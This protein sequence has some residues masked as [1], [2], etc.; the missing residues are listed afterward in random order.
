MVDLPAALIDAVRDQQ[1]VLFFGAGANFGATHPDGEKIPVGDGLR[2]LICDKYFGGSMKSKSLMSVSAFAANEVGL[3][4]FQKYIRDLLE[5]FGPA[6]Y[7]ELLPTFRW[8]AIATTNYDLIVERAYANAASPLQQLIQ[9]FKDNDGFGMRMH[10]ASYPLGYYKLH[11]CIDHYTDDSIPLIL[12]NEQ[13][14]SYAENRK[15]FYNRLRDLGYEFPFIFAGYSITDS[16]I[17]QVLF[18]LT[19]A[20]VKR[21]M[22]YSISPDFEDAEIRY[23]A[24]HRVQCIKMTLEGFLRELDRQIPATARALPAALGGGTLSIRSHY[25]VANATES[26]S[27]VA[28]LATDATHVHSAMPAQQQSP[29]EFYRGADEGWGAIQQNLDAKRTFADSV[30]I[31]AVLVSDDATRAADLFMLKGPAGNGKSVALKRIA[32]EAA[33]TYDRLV[34]FVDNGAALRV[35]AFDEIY[36]LTGKRIL[37]CVDHVALVRTELH[38]L[39]KDLRSRKIPVTILGTERDN[40]WS[41]Y[42][43]QLEPFTAQ[44]FPVRYLNEREINELI[45][46]LE[47]HNA[48]GIL[49]DQNHEARVYAFAKSAERQLLVALHEVTAGIPFEDIVFDEYTRIEPSEARDIYLA[50]CTLHQFGAPVRAG[51]ISR[52]FG[53]SYNDFRDRFIEPLRNIVII[54]EDRHTGDLYYKSRHQHVAEMVFRRALPKEED[55][56][57]LL[58]RMV[59]AINIDYTSDRETFSRLIKGRGIAEVFPNAELGRL[60]YDRV[61]QASPDDPFVFHQRAVFELHHSG[62]AL[63]RAESAI[64]RA[65]ELN[66]R[67]HGIRHTQAEVARRQANN[68][69]DPLKKEALR[70]FARDRLAGNSSHVSEYD[71]YTRARLAIDEVREQLESADLASDGSPPL[72]IESVK[73]AEAAIARGLQEFPENAEILSAEASLR[74]AL[75]QGQ[76][77]Q[78]ALE[79]AFRSNPRQDWLAV[80][81][82]RNYRDSGLTDK[83]LQTLDTCL[84]ENPSSKAAHFEYARLLQDGHGDGQTIL[85]HFRRAFSE[86]DN[87]YEAQYWYAR[88]LFI[89]GR[90]DDS[91]RIFVGINER[92]PGRFR[93][94]SSAPIA[95]AGVGPISLNGKIDRMEEGYGFVRCPV[96]PS[97]L[98]AS[99]A[100]SEANQWTQLRSGT[101]VVTSVAFSRRGPR[102]VNVRAV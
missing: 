10:S 99:R 34:L 1:A 51:L 22:F 2:N 43:E 40:E 60:F 86:G 23:W 81:L 15:R 4:A 19:Q 95:E 32:W 28:F 57:D 18:D 66:P 93:N 91:T 63:M 84:K 89:R 11:G 47:R 8:K 53:I 16:H 7:H 26:S 49:K 48:L 35:D 42:C 67:S 52:V 54:D 97:S 3:I 87:H 37:L 38:Q 41:I 61:D 50:I 55:K 72:F 74:E 68:T 88:E 45:A 59:G 71:L 56:F 92:A 82:A 44:E 39:L 6:S 36:R 80:R 13:Y 9:S 12:S 24:A 46:L 70:R 25:I 79:K 76:Q 65:A 29:K 98:F 102:A 14:A 58:S 27:L 17:Q 20:S 31:D 5:P 101:N 33:A 21:P 30:L 90:F 94:A 96:Y 64:K 100:D 83:A 78:Q 77:A 85:D 69:N 75:K 62:G 73:V